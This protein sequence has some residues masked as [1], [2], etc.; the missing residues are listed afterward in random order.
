MPQREAALAE[1]LSWLGN[2]GSVDAPSIKGAM[3]RDAGEG[4]YSNSTMT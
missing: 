3:L 1:S 2:Q 4:N